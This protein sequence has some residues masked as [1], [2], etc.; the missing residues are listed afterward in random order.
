MDL[1]FF[2]ENAPLMTPETLDPLHQLMFQDEGARHLA[3]LM[4]RIPCLLAGF[5]TFQKQEKGSGFHTLGGHFPWEVFKHRVDIE[6]IL[7][8][9]KNEPSPLTL[10]FYF[11]EQDFNQEL[12]V[13]LLF[14]R[15]KLN[16]EILKFKAKCFDF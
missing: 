3:V 2:T 1:K 13:E 4:N 12:P 9:N 7:H 14:D 16:E 10:R 11:N 6:L 15:E 8:W 5:Y